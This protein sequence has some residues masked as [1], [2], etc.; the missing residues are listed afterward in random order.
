MIYTYQ[1]KSPRLGK[2]VFIAEA[3]VV[4]GDVELG[5]HVSVWPMAVIRGDVNYI[6]I[7]AR[8]NVQDGAVLHVTYRKHP[9]VVG[10][11]VIVAHA[12]VLHGCTIGDHVLLGIGCRVLDG[13][14]THRPELR[15]SGGGLH[16][17]LVDG[18]RHYRPDPAR[19]Q[20]RP[21]A[22]LA[23]AWRRAGGLEVEVELFGLVVLERIVLAGLEGCL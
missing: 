4:G 3:A 6:R 5:D 7:G 22:A 17:A 21:R 8:T 14:E 15:D 1:G 9:L 12:V 13:A 19:R 10:S 11:G 18:R 20:L 23:A 2:G 16:P